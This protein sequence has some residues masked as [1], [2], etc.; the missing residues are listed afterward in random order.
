MEWLFIT[1]TG[2][3]IP[4]VV[5]KYLILYI[6]VFLFSCS[7]VETPK[8]SEK[9]KEL[10]KLIAKYADVD[11]TV[12]MSHLSDRQK[13]LIHKLVE[14]GK[15]PDDIFWKQTSHDALSFKKDL[16][17]KNDEESK[18]ALEFAQINYGP[19]DRL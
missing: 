8:L 5:V 1:I 4:G 18:L 16:E 2:Q 3:N 10:K 19:Y 14:A 11:I 9:S 17:A 7:K 13:L 15:Y 6:F 12:D